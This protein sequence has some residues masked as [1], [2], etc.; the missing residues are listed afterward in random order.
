MTE[1]VMGCRGSVVLYKE[2]DSYCSTC[3]IRVECAEEA[4]QNVQKLQDAL[5]KPVFEAQGK[6]WAGAVMTSRRR[7]AKAYSQSTAKPQDVVVTTAAK[8][9]PSVVAPA[10][11]KLSPFDALNAAQDL[12]VRVR[13]ELERWVRKGIDPSLIEANQNPFENSSGMKFAEMFA[14]AVLKHGVVSKM[15]LQA[16]I[17]ALQQSKGEAAWSSSSL[18]SNINIVAGCFRACGHTVLQEKA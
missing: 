5:S 7:R 12:K 8:P 13:S 10:L 6:W 14:S 15:E 11:C 17:C 2:T 3:P 1:V 18:Q 16:A 4:K 9:N